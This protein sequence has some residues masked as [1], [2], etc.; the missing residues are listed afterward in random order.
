MFIRPCHKWDFL[1]FLPAALGLWEGLSH[2][3]SLRLLVI[4]LKVLPHYASLRL[5]VCAWALGGSV[6]LRFAVFVNCEGV[7]YCLN[8][9]PTLHCLALFVAAKT[10]WRE[11]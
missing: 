11:K 5:F 2:S 7:W 3:A 1:F 8:W 6:S 10:N 9:P 4:V